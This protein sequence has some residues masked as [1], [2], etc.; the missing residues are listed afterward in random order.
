M[1][2][3]GQGWQPAASE[4]CVCVSTNAVS[5]R[6]SSPT[7]N[8]ISACIYITP[9]SLLRHPPVTDPQD[10]RQGV[11]VWAGVGHEQQAC[12]GSGGELLVIWAALL[13]NTVPL[14]KGPPSDSPHPPVIIVVDHI[15]S[16]LLSFFSAG[17]RCGAE[18]SH[19]PRVPLHCTRCIL[20]HPSPPFP[21]SLSQYP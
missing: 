13:A 19:A 14:F 5:P 8:H 7:T 3:G 4:H 11:Q 20:T 1:H 10:A 17:V 15:N 9:S 6:P 18:S 16:L 2:V 21:P 12:K